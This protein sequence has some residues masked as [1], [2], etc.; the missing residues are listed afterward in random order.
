MP[1]EPDIMT[2]LSRKDNTPRYIVI[3]DQ[4][5]DLLEHKHETNE[6][7]EACPICKRVKEI[8]ER[9]DKLEDTCQPP[10]QS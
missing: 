3:G 10:H 7:K 6:D 1:V 4:T 9:L 2:I 5:I 8:N